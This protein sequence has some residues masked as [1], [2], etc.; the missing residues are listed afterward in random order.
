MFIAYNDCL[1]RKDNMIV[2]TENPVKSI[3]ELLEVISFTKFPDTR[4]IQKGNGD[5]II[6]KIRK[7][8]DNSIII[9]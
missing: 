9:I 4:L 1:Y 3:K 6:L 2:Y 5:K 7:L 8:E